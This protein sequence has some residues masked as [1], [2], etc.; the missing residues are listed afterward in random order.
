M[1]DFHDFFVISICFTDGKAK[2]ELFCHRICLQFCAQRCS[3]PAARVWPGRPP[4]PRAW[5][6]PPPPYAR[7]D[8]AVGCGSSRSPR[9]SGLLHGLASWRTVAGQANGPLLP[10]T[11]GPDSTPIHRAARRTHFLVRCQF[12]GC[13]RKYVLCKTPAEPDENEYNRRGSRLPIVYLKTS[14]KSIAGG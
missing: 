2:C 8:S 13:T 6:L 3:P 5:L 11:A 12:M 10:P 4:S 14:R 1:R 9:G 7:P